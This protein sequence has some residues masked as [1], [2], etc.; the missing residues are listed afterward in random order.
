M[1]APH[2]RPPPAPSGLTPAAA[3]TTTTTTNI[4]N[5]AP[6][7][8][9]DPVE[10]LQL[11]HCSSSEEASAGRPTR[12]A[13]K[14]GSAT[15]EAVKSVQ[16]SKSKGK[17]VAKEPADNGQGP[18]HAVEQALKTKIGMVQQD[19]IKTLPRTCGPAPCDPGPSCWAERQTSYRDVVVKPRTFKPRF[20]ARH[21]KLDWLHEGSWKEG[22][23]EGRS[24]RERLE[25]REVRAPSIL[26]RLSVGLTNQGLQT[27][28]GWESLFLVL[29][30]A[31]A[32]ARR[33]FNCFALDHRISQC[34]DPPKCLHCSRSGHKARFC[35]RRRGS[36]ADPSAAVVSLAA[37]RWRQKVAV[38]AMMDRM[39]F[40]PG[41]YDMRPH[42]VSAAAPRTKAIRVEERDLE[43]STLVAVQWD[44]SVLV[45]CATVLRYAPHQLRIL[46][47]ELSIE[48]LSRVMFL[49]RFRSRELRTMA[50]AARSFCAGNIEL[51]I[52]SWS[53]RIGAKLFSN[54]SFIDEI[55][56]TVE[57][58]EEWFCFNVWVW[59]DAPNDLALQGILQVE[60]PLDLPDEQYYGMSDME[61]PLVR[62][63]PAKTF[64]YE[65][66]IHLDRVLD[67]SSPSDSLGRCSYDSD[68]SGIPSED[69]PQPDYPEVFPFY[70]SLGERDGGRPART[71]S[72]HDRRGGGGAAGS[73]AASW[74]R[75]PGSRVQAKAPD[76]TT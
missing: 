41:D 4:T 67:Y 11:N 66:L 38:R 64:D 21:E 36:E 48:G 31:K 8:V 61:L 26:D 53:R 71:R 35:P 6:L 51:N 60:E 16:E 23:R 34:R 28:K 76:D 74:G 57:K 24:V 32:G 59:T 52:M 10:A 2:E 73:L 70:C 22:R 46:A 56:C 30:K 45:L 19:K 13:L 55:D 15:D 5:L 43:L 17:A 58:E 54:Q 75:R 25:A 44:A 69:P 1:S 20:P 29:V 68:I 62:D 37:V 42:W 39:E 33:C 9:T 47:H 14:K 50:L 72:V 40:P 27:Q 12:G 49:L 65:I 7:A 18:G 3:T 63:G